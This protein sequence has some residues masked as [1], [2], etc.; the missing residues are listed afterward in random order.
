MELPLHF[1]SSLGIKSLKGVS[2]N[3]KGKRYSDLL[4]T[5]LPSVLETSSAMQGV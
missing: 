3:E 5:P 4:S 1:S 2:F